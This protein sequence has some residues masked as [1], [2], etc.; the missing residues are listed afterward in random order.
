MCKPFLIGILHRQN[1]SAPHSLVSVFKSDVSQVPHV[2]LVC[3]ISCLTDEG[4][5]LPRSLA[6]ISGCLIYVLSYLT[7]GRMLS[8]LI[9]L[10]ACDDSQHLIVSCIHSAH[11]SCH[12]VLD[13]ALLRWPSSGGKG[14]SAG[15]SQPGCFPL[16]AF[17]ENAEN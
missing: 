7:S 10:K 17:Y 2:P 4:Y 3:F 16:S 6:R 11:T 14:N 1:F 5:T 13:S 8:V 15:S 9:L 12:A